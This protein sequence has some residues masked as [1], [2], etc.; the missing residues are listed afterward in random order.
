VTDRLLP[1]AIVLAALAAWVPWAWQNQARQPVSGAQ[2][3]MPM[4]L[5]VGQDG[6]PSVIWPDGQRSPCGPP[7]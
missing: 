1:V 7:P 5:E 2:T 4:R 6:T 3:A